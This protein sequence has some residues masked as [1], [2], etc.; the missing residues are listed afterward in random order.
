[1]TKSRSDMPHYADTFI[2]HLVMTT[3]HGPSVLANW[4]A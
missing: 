3:A 1:M 4:L 2:S